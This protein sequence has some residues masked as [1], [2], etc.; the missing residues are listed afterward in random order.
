MTKVFYSQKHE[1]MF[2]GGKFR[3]LVAAFWTCS[4]NYGICSLDFDMSKIS[5]IKTSADPWWT[6]YLNKID[7][8]CVE[9][10]ERP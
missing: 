2:P 8:S 6:K 4:I 7:I 3:F 10:F 5:S 1:K 9:K